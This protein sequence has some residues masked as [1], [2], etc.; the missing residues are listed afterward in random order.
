MGKG[1]YDYS[2]ADKDSSSIELIILAHDFQEVENCMP[3]AHDISAY[4]FDSKQI[5]RI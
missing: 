4:V 5:S 1:Y 3:E 2:L